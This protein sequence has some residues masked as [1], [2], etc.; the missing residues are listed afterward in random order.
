V[1]SLASAVS[2]MVCFM[3]MV[4]AGVKLL[5]PVRPHFCYQIPMGPLIPDNRNHTGPGRPRIGS[6]FVGVRLPPD[7][8]APLDAWIGQ[9][10]DPKPTRPEA[11]RRLI[12]L[13]LGTAKADQDETS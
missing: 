7:R 12:E 5:L 3:V 10:Q 4:R 6:I 11:I 1:K 8:L 2:V 13:G 9:H